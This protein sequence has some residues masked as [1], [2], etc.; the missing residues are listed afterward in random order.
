MLQGNLKDLKNLAFTS[1]T[2]MGQKM[3]RLRLV[4]HRIC[5]HV[6]FTFFVSD[7]GD[8]KSDSFK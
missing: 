5:C 4:S 2:Y 6:L 8:G 1:I 7:D 3:A